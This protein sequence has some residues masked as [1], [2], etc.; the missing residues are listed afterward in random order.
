MV[1]R[2][3]ATKEDVQISAV[4]LQIQSKFRFRSNICSIFKDGVRLVNIEPSLQIFQ[5]LFLMVQRGEAT[6]E[7]VQISAVVLQIQSKFRFRS[8]IC[9]V[10]RYSRMEL[11]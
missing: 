2:S 9:S 11:D 10:G 7:D 5:S 1:Q 3:E 4:V 8:N 6:T